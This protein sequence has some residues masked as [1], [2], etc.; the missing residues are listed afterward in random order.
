MY[1]KYFLKMKRGLLV[2]HALIRIFTL[3]GWVIIE[4]GRVYKSSAKHGVI[5]PLT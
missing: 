5:F 4:I 2:A 1:T 3:K